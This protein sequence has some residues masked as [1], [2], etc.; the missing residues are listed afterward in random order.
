MTLKKLYLV[1]ANPLSGVGTAGA[2]VAAHTST[3]AL[4]LAS[5]GP[6][7]LHDPFINPMMIGY[8]SKDIKKCGVL[9]INNGELW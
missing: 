3:E 1:K 9:F 6:D 7:G 5:E 4:R 2:V 8:A